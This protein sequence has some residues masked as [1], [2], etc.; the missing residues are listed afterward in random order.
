MAQHSLEMATL[1]PEPNHHEMHELGI[2]SDILTTV[3]ETA[4]AAGARR[5]VSI[6]LTVGEMRDLVPEWMQN[7]FDHCALGTAAQ[8]AKLLFQR[9]PVRLACQECGAEF[10][11]EVRSIR[12]IRCPSCSSTRSSVRTGL[13]LRIEGIEV[14]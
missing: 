9:V 14:E 10:A 2:T 4:E 8:G 11:A 3:L 7:Y 1:T 6:S 12:Q 13:E 5:I